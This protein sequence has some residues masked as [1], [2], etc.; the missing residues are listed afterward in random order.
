MI[1]FI[2]DNRFPTFLDKLISVSRNETNASYIDLSPN[3][4][5]DGDI[6]TILIKNGSDILYQENTDSDFVN[7]SQLFPYIVAP[8]KYLLEQGINKKITWVKNTTSES[9]TWKFL[10]YTCPFNTVCSPCPVVYYYA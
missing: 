1:N 9:K 5:F 2:K 8:R 6:G 10:G 7:L 3:N 4:L